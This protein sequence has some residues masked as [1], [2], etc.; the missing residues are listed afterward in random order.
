MKHYTEVFNNRR[1]RN[2]N[3]SQIIEE[4]IKNSPKGAIKVVSANDGINGT[5]ATRV[6]Y[7]D[8][9]RIK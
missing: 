3:K 9:E 8:V 6:I 2:Y 1:M 7:D 5:R 4:L